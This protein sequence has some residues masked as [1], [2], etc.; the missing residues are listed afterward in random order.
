MV[1][2]VLKRGKYFLA[3][4]AIFSF[5]AALVS[6]VLAEKRYTATAT[7]LPS[8]SSGAPE[9][10]F[11]SRN[12][13]DIG[14]MLSLQDSGN[15]LPLY[16]DILRS[17][18]VARDILRKNFTFHE[19]GNDVTRTLKDHFGMEN[20]DAALI[21]LSKAVSFRVDTESKTL[22]L[23]ATMNN[24]ELSARVIN[25]Y[26]SRLERFNRMERRSCAKEV[27]DFIEGKLADCR[28]EMRE[29]EESLMAFRE[30]N[31]NYDSSTEPDLQK[32][33]R[34]L[35][36]RVELEK[37]LCLELGKQLKQAVV[38]VERD[39][40]ILNVLDYAGVPERPSWPKPA[41]FLSSI[42]TAGLLLGLIYLGAVESF[43]MWRAGNDRETVD[44][45]L[46]ELKKDI[47]AVPFIGERVG[48]G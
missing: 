27:Y 3:L 39:T 8:A 48:S 12:L 31:R 24:A 25:A 11:T 10:A 34:R 2:G 23:Q 20:E 30:K 9:L 29:A 46:S 28:L 7:V 18:L 45:L 38:D 35:I 13:S 36:R 6:L 43:G 14:L 1:F 33:H 5:S 16:P 15:L 4:M 32:D 44:K 21:A 22:V 17:R 19:N 41:L 42:T 40:P 37:A 47:R 26:I